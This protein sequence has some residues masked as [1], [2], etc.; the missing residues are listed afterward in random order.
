MT[1][2]VRQPARRPG[3]KQLYRLLGAYYSSFLLLGMVTAVLGPSLIKLAEQTGSSLAGVSVFFPVRAGSYLLG[4]W[5]AGRLF[6]RIKGHQLL[7]AALSVMGTALVLVP[8]I[9]QQE[10]MVG[11]LVVMG[12]GMGLIDV[13]CNTLLLWTVGERPGPYLN[14]LHFFYGLGSLIAPIFLALAFER[15]QGVS[16][17]YWAAAAL[18]VPILLQLLSLSSPAQAR[19]AARGV[20]R[21]E[22][23]RAE[24]RK[25]VLGSGILLLAVFLFFYVGVEVG[26]GGWI[27]TYGLKLNLES[28]VSGAYLTSV[29][30]GTFTLGRLLSVPLSDRLSPGKMLAADLTVGTGALL[31]LALFPPGTWVTRIL[32]V[33]LGLALASVFPSTLAL[34]G[35]G[36][37]LSARATS[38]FFV[39]GGLG[40]VFLP[41]LI[42]VLISETGSAAFPYVLLAS[43]LAGISVLM[44]YLV[45]T[46]SGGAEG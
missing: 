12:L 27:F 5:L 37:E 45:R 9:P 43:C 8:I 39:S 19:K 28:E 38:W 23:G 15:Q 29:F 46:Q 22:A 7:A 35:K 18:T 31:A 3:R 34:A 33:I 24:D 36:Q 13:G 10:M 20:A 40:A 21:P 2:Q 32:T 4:S 16:L 6:D 42:G 14:G 1:E 11:V 41:W 44:V 26:F 17:G 25:D 30:W